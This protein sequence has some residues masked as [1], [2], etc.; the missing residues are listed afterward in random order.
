MKDFIKKNYKKIIVILLLLTFTLIAYLIKADLI[1][2]FDSFIYKYL[3]I[4]IS[5]NVTQIYKI[6]TFL[7]SAIM[8]III[9]ILIFIIFKNK[10]YGKLV[11]L[12]LINVVVIN[13]VLKIVFSRE[14]PNILMLVDE[15]GYSFPSGHAMTSTAFYGF[16]IYLI[17]QTNLKKDKKYLF[18]IILLSIILTVCISRIYLGVHYASD[19]V[20]GI[21]LSL[22][23][24]IIYVN[25]I[26]KYL[27]KSN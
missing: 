22:V 7:S 4:G 16:L 17:W 21:C 5:A 10:I 19:V 8:V 3:S 26:K 23:Y 15:K 2:G 6:V 20:A 9:T 1:N 24:L 27:F 25:L 11:S 14:R 13:Q 12:N 18:T